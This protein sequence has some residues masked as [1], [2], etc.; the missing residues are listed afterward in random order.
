MFKI[1]NGKENLVTARGCVSWQIIG[2]LLHGLLFKK[3]KKKKKLYF[4]EENRKF[5]KQIMGLTVLFGIIHGFYYTIL[6]NFYYYL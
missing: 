2:I 1:L 3:F 6:A 5:I 4:I